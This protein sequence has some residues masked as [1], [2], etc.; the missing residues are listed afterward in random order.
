M[1]CLLGGAA[2][3]AAAPMPREPGQPAQQQQHPAQG[4]EQRQQVV[5]VV[6]HVLPA[7]LLL[8][9]DRVTAAAARWAGLYRLAGIV[10]AAPQPLAVDPCVSWL[11]RGSSL[12]LTMM[13][14]APAGGLEV[15][16]RGLSRKL[17]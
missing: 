12:M 6:R 10:R 17:G 8:Y 15:R 14:A 13:R 5:G 16:F 4:D 7:E 3:A 11:P 2:G 9:L 1:S